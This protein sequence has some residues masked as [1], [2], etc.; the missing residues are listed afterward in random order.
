MRFTPLC[1]ALLGAASLADA[2]LL[3]D[4]TSTSTPPGWSQVSPASSSAEVEFLL[5][6]PQQRLPELESLFL[7]VSTPG[8]PQYQD[9]KSI[10]EIRVII[11]PPQEDQ[12]EV[13]SWLSSVGVKNITNN[14]DSIRV[15]TTVARA[16][17]LFDTSFS[18]FRHSETGRE[19]ISSAGP[20]SLPSSMSN[21]ISFVDGLSSFPVGKKARLG[22]KKKTPTAGGGQYTITAPS[23]AAVYGTPGSDFAPESNLSSQNVVQFAY[24]TYSPEGMVG[25][26]TSV[27]WP[28]TL[29]TDETTV[30]P[31]TDGAQIEAQLDVI[32][33]S[34]V[35]T[36][37]EQWFWLEDGTKWMLSFSDAFFNTPDIPFVNSISYAWSELDQCGSATS[38]YDCNTFGVDSASLVDRTNTNFM[39]I[40]LRGASLLVASG[41]SGVWGRT[42]ETCVGKKF[43][44]DFPACS[45][46]VTSVAATYTPAPVYFDGAQP[47]CG[48]KCLAG[49]EEVGVSYRDCGF[50][51]GG[52]F[53]NFSPMPDYQADA[54][55]KYLNSGVEL[56]TA[57]LF[58]A[59][60]R[61][62]PD[63]S[64]QGHN[65]LIYTDET[66]SMLVG[67][68]S[69]ASPALGGMV[70]LWND[71]SLAETGKPLGFL[72]PLIYS[73]YAS[74]PESF[75]DVLTGDNKCTEGGCSFKCT[76]GFEATTGFDLVSGVGVPNHKAILEALKEL[77]GTNKARREKKDAALPS[78]STSIPAD[79]YS[80]DMQ[81]YCVSQCK[82]KGYKCI[83]ENYYWCCDNM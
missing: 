6:L 23:Y 25:Y 3:F 32:A 47:A 63:I 10:D 28:M 73:L 22:G 36:G 64:L 2:R 41:D 33:M 54:V 82:S 18:I 61:A 70:S 15:K 16:A 46:W 68:T 58:N 9:F 74:N 26:E 35:G 71:Y 60:N 4:R 57:S 65:I 17:K 24:E 38:D 34:S 42:A 80:A 62:F 45:P 67:G 1:V 37:V 27:G 55:A 44:P 83:N 53:S 51:S 52:G 13:I 12:D 30:G 40:G 79:C 78:T 56:P 14:G 20:S 50:V 31:E 66:N 59:T 69:A 43:R 5:L 76:E 81:S 7:S 29:P 75:T 21:L 48:S 39:K 77:L 8:S 11:S 49:G 72:N 19:I